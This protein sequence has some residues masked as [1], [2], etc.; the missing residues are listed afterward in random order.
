[1]NHFLENS[2]TKI[3]TLSINVR[4]PADVVKGQGL[5]LTRWNGLNFFIILSQIGIKGVGLKIHMLE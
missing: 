3:I 4:N 5:I 2:R 1:M